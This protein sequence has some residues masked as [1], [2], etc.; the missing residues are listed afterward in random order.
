MS[1]KL[2]YEKYKKK[3]FNSK[4]SDILI[5]GFQIGGKWNVKW[6]SIISNELFDYIVNARKNQRK[7]I[8]VID[9][10]GGSHTLSLWKNTYNTYSV[11]DIKNKAGKNSIDHWTNKLGN[12]KD[13]ISKLDNTSSVD[14]IRQQ[15]NTESE[16]LVKSYVTSLKQMVANISKIDDSTGYQFCYDYI[17]IRQTGKIRAILHEKKDGSNIIRQRLL[18][19]W[20]TCMRKHLNNNKLSNV[21]YQLLDNSLEGKMEGENFE[22]ISSDVDTYGKIKLGNKL[23]I[24]LAIM[25]G[26]S[27]TQMFVYK[28]NQDNNGVIVLPKV[29]FEPKLGATNKNGIQLDNNTELIKNIQNIL[30]QSKTIDEDIKPKKIYLM[31]AFKYVMGEIFRLATAEVTVE[32]TTEAIFSKIGVTYDNNIIKIVNIQNLNIFIN[33]LET[34]K[35]TYQVKGKVQ[36][37]KYTISTIIGFFK[38][39]KEVINDGEIYMAMNTPVIKYAPLGG[40]SVSWVPT[41]MENYGS[42]L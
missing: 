17:I 37:D 4:K 32:V 5:G 3:Y 31:N 20:N 22:K 42:I 10:G 29:H 19:I 7:M 21:D 16:N 27:S 13:D 12:L 41:L 2:K 33:Y 8:A 28:N 39:L 18:N 24:G 1:Y 11:K 14:N 36:N 9:N 35:S 26:S 30:N 34:I 23:D 6:S 15:I 38:I 40:Q 25:M